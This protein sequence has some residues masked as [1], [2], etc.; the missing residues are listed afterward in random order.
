M[1]WTA[2]SRRR[3]P[4]EE[5]EGKTYE[6]EYQHA[7]N[8]AR[9]RSAV[10]VSNIVEQ[11]YVGRQREKKD[12]DYRSERFAVLGVSQERVYKERRHKRDRRESN[13]I[14]RSDKEN[15]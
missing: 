4:N 3:A 5:L 13:V 12:F 11:E 10:F 1:T 7:L 8:D 9:K 15:L 14:E 6:E 2:N